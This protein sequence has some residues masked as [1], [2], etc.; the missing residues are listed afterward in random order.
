ML[1]LQSREFLLRNLLLQLQKKCLKILQNF[2]SFSHFFAVF[3]FAKKCEIS[4]KSSFNTNAKFPHFFAKVSFTGNRTTTTSG[5]SWRCNKWF[6]DE[7]TSLL[8]L[9]TTNV[10]NKDEKIFTVS[11][12]SHSLWVTLYTAFNCIL[13]SNFNSGKRVSQ[14]RK[15]EKSNSSK[16]KIIFINLY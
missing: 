5:N 16:N 8:L 12:K 2:E 15:K 10:R 14:Q 11:Q 1:S 9:W 13:S 7:K 3:I 6:C 4:R